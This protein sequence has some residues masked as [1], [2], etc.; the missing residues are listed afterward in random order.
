MVV[1][2]KTVVTKAEPEPILGSLIPTDVGYFPTAARHAKERPEGI[3]QAILI[4]CVNGAGWCRSEGKELAIAPGQLLIVPPG[5]AHKYGAAQRQPWSIHWV[6]VKGR[7]LLPF[8]EHFGD[9]R[10]ASSVF[11]G[12]DAQS[13]ALF[14]EVLELCEQ[15]HSFSELLQAGQALSHLMA[16]LARRARETHTESADT[17]L[18]IDQSV[19][20]L[21]LHF[22]RD[23][24]LQTLAR[25]AGLSPSRFS[26]L[27]K[28]RTGHS[29]MSYLTRL[30]LHRAARLL[31][32]T[33]QSVKSISASVG[34]KDQLYFSRVFRAAHGASPSDYRAQRSS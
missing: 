34:Y 1:L 4:Y 29:P 20:F 13:A 9:L 31:E 22:E 17:D 5:V 16:R 28:A 19:D 7:L 18:R 33:T 21:E 12:K 32:T 14:G 2:P 8:L 30:R 27:F 10:R 25:L 26:A 6:H 23:I 11:V 3:D 24:D 15:G